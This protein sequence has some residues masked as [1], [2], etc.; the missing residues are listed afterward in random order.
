MFINIDQIRGETAYLRD[1][2]WGHWLAQVKRVE[3]SKERIN[4][5]IERRRTYDRDALLLDQLQWLK[6]AGFANVDCVYKNYF[7]GVFIAC[8]M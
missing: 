3:S 5:S 1:L 8:K 4:A 2:Y 7:V 6:D